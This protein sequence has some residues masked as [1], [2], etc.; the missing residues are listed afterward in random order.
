[1]T[2]P[3]QRSD[4]FSEDNASTGS[5]QAQRPAGDADVREVAARWPDIVTSPRFGFRARVTR[6]L[7]RKAVERLNVRV[8]VQR[9][10]RPRE[11]WGAGD[12]DS[13][14][15]YLVNPDD[16]FARI[17]AA[18]L[19]G[20]GESYLAGDWLAGPDPLPGGPDPMVPLLTVFASDLPRL[21]PA[22]LQKLRRFA[23]RYQPRSEENT[24]HGSR[25]NISRHYDLSNDLFAAFL[26][27]TLTYSAALF[28]T[29]EEPGDP[30]SSRP[31]W[32]DL[33]VAQARKIERLLDACGVGAGTRLL[34]IGTGWGELALRA[35]ARG[36]VVHSITLSEE[37]LALARQRVAEAGLTDRVTIELCDYRAVTG[38][39]DAV[40]SVEMIEA[41]GDSYW[42]VYF[43]TLSRVLAPGGRIGLQAIT[44][45]H[46]RML[47]S[48]NTY[49][50]IQKYVFPGGLI[51]SVEAIHSVA[52]GAGLTV[53]DDL[54]FGSGYAETL[55]LWRERF[56]AASDDIERLGFDPVFQ[57]MWTLYLAWSEAGFRA[58]YL[59]VHQLVLTSSR[60]N[61]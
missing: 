53:V 61:S 19:I 25:S 40:V 14:I 48:R 36:A 12:Q 28:D 42:P 17:G 31:E 33:A 34:E 60:E 20:V 59:D 11:T 58:R 39:F 38:Q 29:F 46:D 52:A 24:P 50:W 37:Q 10:A 6:A 30:A 41:V 49:T 8:V 16:F 57:R 51:P 15:M 56:T 7:F 5:H 45:P 35:A 43:S 54:A 22:P 13:P 26:D 18:G 21:I 1:M 44:M 27:P 32:P 55:R 9:P 3:T 4:H 23:V 2:A 47:A